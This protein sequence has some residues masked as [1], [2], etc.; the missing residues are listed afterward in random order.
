M[1]KP[2]QRVDV[3]ARFFRPVN[4]TKAGFAA[5]S[6]AVLSFYAIDPSVTPVTD[7]RDLLALQASPDFI[8]VAEVD[9]SRNPGVEDMRW[10]PVADAQ[11]L[12]EHRRSLANGTTKAAQ[13]GAESG[14]QPVTT[15]AAVVPVPAAKPQ[16]GPT[17][18]MGKAA[19]TKSA[20]TAVTTSAKK[21]K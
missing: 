10:V 9:V 5:P 12:L 21:K 3:A 19:V 8:E 13:Q 1:A 2:K 20:P 14:N 11:A 6:G 18:T 4:G 17:R 15:K 16:T 7:E